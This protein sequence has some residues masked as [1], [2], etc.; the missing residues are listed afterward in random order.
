M[1]EVIHN[2]SFSGVR[3]CFRK[4]IEIPAQTSANPSVQI[5]AGAAAGPPVPGP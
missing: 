3:L 1:T 2:S 5:T 4:G